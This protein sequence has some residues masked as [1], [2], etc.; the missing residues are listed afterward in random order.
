MTTTQEYERIEQRREQE[1]Q[2]AARGVCVLYGRHRYAEH[3]ESPAGPRS[4]VACECGH[5][6]R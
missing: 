4:V 1:R 2:D 6:P 5:Q 3:D